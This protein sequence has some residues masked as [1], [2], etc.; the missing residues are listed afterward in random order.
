M[1]P[2]TSPRVIT[3]ADELAS[4]SRGVH[5]QGE[6][7]TLVPT[8]GNLHR[9]HLALVSEAAK[10]GGRVVVSIFVNP[11]QFG[12]GE[13]FDR[14]PRTLDADIDA[15]QGSGADI[16]FAPSADEV[17][18]PGAEQELLSAGPVGEVLE[19]ATRPGHFDAVVRVCRRLFDMSA[20]DTAVFGQ[21]DAQ[22]L[23]V[24][25]QMARSLSTPVKIV[26]VPTVRDADGLALSSRNA[27]LSDEDRRTAVSLPRALEEADAALKAGSDL[28][29][30]MGA[31]QLGLSSQGGLDLDYFEAVNPE[32]F[33][34]ASDS[35][36][37]VL[38][39]A[40]VSV[41]GTRL[42]DNRLVS[43]SK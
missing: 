15:L 8:M 28:S 5:A 39:V 11:T 12:A 22:Q 20:T 17:Y 34:E 40:A 31:A 41:G 43:R 19:G 2:L 24:V 27:Y 14:Y 37:Q 32:T 29:A 23:H 18:P 1:T 25:R 13:D 26:S 35:D 30:A 16:V 7:V 6:Q 10:L 33:E 3:T 21:K 4:W 9:G 36:A 38:L 42:I